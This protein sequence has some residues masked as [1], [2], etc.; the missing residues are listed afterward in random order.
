MER[1]ICIHYDSEDR[2]TGKFVDLCPEDV[3]IPELGI[4]PI[5]IRE[6]SVAVYS[7]PRD[8]DLQ[9]ILAL[10]EDHSPWCIYGGWEEQD[11]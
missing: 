2:D 5:E 10:V 1:K 7:V 6:G 11:E 8:I 3:R 9:A 4:L